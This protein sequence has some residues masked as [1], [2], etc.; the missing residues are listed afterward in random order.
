MHNIEPPHQHS[1]SP[2]PTRLSHQYPL[3]CPSASAVTIHHGAI[4][5]LCSCCTSAE[6]A[7]Y[8]YKIFY[9]YF[10]CYFRVIF[11]ARGYHKWHF[12]QVQS[13]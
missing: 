7:P 13:T 2:F 6:D 4:H 8:G 12:P 10:L 5:L 11:L 9:Y 3:P 1:S